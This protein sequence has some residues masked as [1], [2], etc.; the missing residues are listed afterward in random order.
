MYEQF[1]YQL[2]QDGLSMTKP[3]KMV[4][5]SIAKNHG[6]TISQLTQQLDGKA[7][8]ASIYR[9]VNTLEDCGIIK[10]VY[11]GWKYTL[12]LSEGYDND[13]HHHL[14]CT[15]C[16]KTI[17]TEHDVI[18]ERMINEHALKYGFTMSSHELDIQGVCAQ[19]RGF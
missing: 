9:V 17:H 10:R 11:V 18:L 6:I 15:H 1:E 4:F 13:H 16:N 12:E 19:C 14:H 8:R 3:R 2:R 7:H 5:D